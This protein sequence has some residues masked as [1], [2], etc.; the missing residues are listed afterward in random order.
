MKRA[1]NTF[2]GRISRRGL[3]VMLLLATA[4][5]GCEKFL[6]TKPTD[7]LTP[8]TYYNTEDQLNR[9]LIGVYDIFGRAEVYGEY[10]VWE[11]NST[12]D[13][14]YQFGNVTTGL[15]SYNYDAANANVYNFWRAL[16]QGI[17]RANTLL[18]N[19]NK[20]VMDE[21]KRGIIR[22]EALFL[23]G[24]YY[25][26]LAMNFGDVPLITNGT[27]SV[28]NTDIARTPL[29]Q[30]YEQVLKDMTTADTLL[31]RQ[32]ATVLGFGGRVSKTAVEGILARVCLTMAGAPLHDASKYQLA[33]AY[34][35]RVI[36]SGEHALNPDYS[37]IFINYAQDKYDVKESM[38]EIE[39]QGNATGTSDES[40]RIGSNVG[41]KCSSL[42]IGFGYASVNATNELYNLYEAYPAPAT[43]KPSPDLR[44]DWNCANYYWGG[45]N[46]TTRVANN[47]LWAL[48]AGKW[49]REYETLTPKNKNQTPQ[50]FP[51][52]RY[53]DVLLMKAEADNEINGPT[54]AA[55]DAVNLV[56]RRGYGKLLNGET[57]KTIAI[58]NGGTGYTTAP[59]VTI[60]GGGGTGATATATV[61]G[62]KV[63]A[64]TITAFGKNF[65]GAPAIGFTGGGGTGATATATITTL[66][67]ADLT[68]AQTSDKDVFRKAIQDERSREL[69]F[70]THRRTDLI[71]WGIFLSTMHA[72][73]DDV[74]ARAPASYKYIAWSP[75]LVSEK[76]LLMPIPAHDMNV[77]KLLV[78]NPGW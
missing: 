39:F 37:Q 15:R 32:T 76:H 28:S 60:T 38:W 49:R 17:Q 3:C 12:T 6:D 18:D 59:T 58:T 51:V 4:I 5:S 61:S 27:V 41:I 42:D 9:G 29:K 34:A 11:I 16:W 63:T 52:L 66:T 77:N 72:L 8:D 54:Q 64:I 73:A 36:E 33:L 78:Q 57:L 53:A 70:E 65:T 46:N 43:I 35:N 10:M 1:T 67:D 25:F 7:S 14:T 48:N 30:V 47:D 55:I 74:N 23:R 68:A 31:T 19:I 50:N 71:R 20:P 56:R 24:Y 75:A 22:G 26:L 69:C 45:S 2:P 44:R 13:E 21:T 40:G 62:G